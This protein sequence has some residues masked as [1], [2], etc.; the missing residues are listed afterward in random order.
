M[1]DPETEAEAFLDS[2][3]RTLY[4]LSI[5]TVG[6]REYIAAVEI[7]QTTRGSH[8]PHNTPDTG[9]S[10]TYDGVTGAVGGPVDSPDGGG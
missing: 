4:E 2:A 10:A 1:R 9:A 7:R 5:G 3:P 6:V 8:Q